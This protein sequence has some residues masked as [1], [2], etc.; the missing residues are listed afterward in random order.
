MSQ[1]MISILRVQNISFNFSWEFNS[2]S[3]GFVAT[4]GWKGSSTY[5]GIEGREKLHNK[6]L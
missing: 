2:K 5:M 4:E 3:F 1:K 6:G